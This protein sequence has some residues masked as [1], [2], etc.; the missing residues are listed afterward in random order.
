MLLDFGPDS[1]HRMAQEKLDWPNL[2]V[3]WIS[4]FHLDHF[5]G[6]VPFLFSLKWSPQ[7]Q[8]RTKS[9][10]IFGPRGL[11][12]IIDAINDANNYRLFKQT[13]NVVV[14][15]IAPNEHFE[16]LPRIRATTLKTNHNAES[17]AIRLTEDDEKTFV[18]TSDTGFTNDLTTFA[19]CAD[20]LLLE[21]SFITNKPLETH[22]ELTE[23]IEIAKS[24]GARKLVLTHLYPEWD[25]V[26]V[27]A[28]ARALWQGDIV[29]AKDG[30]V[31]RT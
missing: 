31:L 27:V 15:E 29:E 12:R 21:C 30:L 16:M 14:T 2:D 19:A 9:L 26:D 22:L 5:G 23:A 17:L 13:F 10:R 20:V 7:T 28:K 25:E 4:H 3:I 18:Y 8:G 24:C 11:N 1:A 6:L